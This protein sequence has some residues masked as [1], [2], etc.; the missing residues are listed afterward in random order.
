MVLHKKSFSESVRSPKSKL[1]ES[2]RNPQA[3]LTEF[4]RCIKAAL[5]ILVFA[6]AIP[7]QG[8]CCGAPGLSAS[9]KE[10]AR[11][12]AAG[13]ATSNH[14]SIYSVMR[15]WRPSA[16]ISQ[17]DDV[18]RRVGAA[19]GVDWR[20]LSAIAYHESRFK[21]HVVSPAGA[22]G[23]MQ[24]RPVVARHFNVEPSRIGEVETNVWLAARLIRTLDV[25]LG[26]P[27]ETAPDD[28]L[29]LILACYNAGDGNVSIARKMTMLSGGDPNSWGSVSRF[30][31]RGQTNAF[32]RGVLALYSDY[33]L[34]AAV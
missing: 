17:Y 5:I 11:A 16:E 31:R 2:V 15:A 4:S 29:G 23:L 9:A 8:L 12:V 20:L 18:L 14:P 1:L 21:A 34:I 13:V 30:L 26:L 32:V 3:A 28:R 33:C 19:Q 27:V 7:L 22:R 24:V 10:V 6:L 25:K